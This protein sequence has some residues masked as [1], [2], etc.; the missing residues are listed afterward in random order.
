MTVSDSNELVPVTGQWGWLQP[1]ANEIKVISAPVLARKL[2]PATGYTS[3]LS[4]LIKRSDQAD[5]IA[6]Q[7]LGK[8]RDV[9]LQYTYQSI[10]GV[11]S[12]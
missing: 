4:Q 12:P 5:S 8:L 9:H 2:L 3:H 1:G 7:H 10:T 11:V 6:K